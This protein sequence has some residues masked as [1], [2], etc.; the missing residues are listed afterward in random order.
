MHRSIRMARAVRE[1]PQSREFQPNGTRRSI[2]QLLPPRRPV[3]HVT[4]LGLASAKPGQPQAGLPDVQTTEGDLVAHEVERVAVDPDICASPAHADGKRRRASSLNPSV[5][6]ASDCFIC[7]ASR[8]QAAAMVL[9]ARKT[10]GTVTI[11]NVPIAS[12]TK[13]R[14]SSVPTA[15]DYGR[16]VGMR[17]DSGGGHP[18]ESAFVPLEGG[19]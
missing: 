16:G 17:P 10:S 14:K 13:A 4:L 1:V 19:G 11:E 7:S 6:R 3:L 12:T 8:S 9:F 18:P 15:R 2:R 5:V